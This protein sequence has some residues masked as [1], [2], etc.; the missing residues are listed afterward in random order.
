MDTTFL[1]VNVFI[2]AFS[3]IGD[4][5]YR[6]LGADLSWPP[7]TPFSELLQG[8]KPAPLVV[9]RTVKAEIVSD[10]PAGKAE[11]MN[12]IDKAWMENG[13]YGVIQFTR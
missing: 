1:C 3:I 12:Q 10:L 8:F 2:M 11:E 13:D 9:I 4:L 5:N 7:T 6:K